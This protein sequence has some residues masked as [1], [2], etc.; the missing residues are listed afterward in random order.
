MS[1]CNILLNTDNIIHLKFC[2][3]LSN[4]DG[5]G[6]VHVNMCLNQS[7]SSSHATKRTGDL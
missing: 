1:G 7:L 5:K 2:R 4:F 3:K 6:Y